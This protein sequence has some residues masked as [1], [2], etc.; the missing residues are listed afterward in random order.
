[1]KYIVPNLRLIV[2]TSLLVG[3]MVYL[4]PEIL[5]KG[6]GQAPGGVP[7]STLS[8][9][10][11]PEGAVVAVAVL[12]QRFADGAAALAASVAI[13]FVVLNGARLTFAFGN[14][15]SL[16]K[17]K[18]GLM[19]AAGGLVLI[20]FA[21]IVTKSVIAL[22]YSGADGSS[23][24]GSDM[25]NAPGSAILT[26]VAGE[27]NPNGLC[28]QVGVLPSPCY[29][30]E[31]L[32]NQTAL[33]EDPDACNE[34]AAEALAGVCSDLGIDD[35]TIL[36]IQAAIDYSELGL[37]SDC[38]TPDGLYGQCTFRALQRLYQTQCIE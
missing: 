3:L 37:P 8:S 29:A 4:S 23:V 11:S 12:M 26:P 18:K 13:F 33:E 36:N 16:G 24:I 31:D 27:E 6:L 7:G 2:A 19:W 22:T 28:K 30:A 35:C 20:I 32:A 25:I 1:M 9:G 34:A 17:A 10:D 21:Y 15:E 38:T 14:T 5:A